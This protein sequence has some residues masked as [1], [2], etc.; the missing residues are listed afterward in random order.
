MPVYIWAE[1]PG[2]AARPLPRVKAT[3]F[4]DGYEQRAPDGLHPV[5]QVWDVVHDSIDVAVADEI[6]A[7]LMDGLGWKTFDW[8]PPRQA[9]AR[10]FKCTSYSRTLTD[11]VGEHSISATFEEVHEP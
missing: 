1:S 9:T 7:F 10:K 4:G 5:K 3:Q 2:T 11:R 6:D 8:T